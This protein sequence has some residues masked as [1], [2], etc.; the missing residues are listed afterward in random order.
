M[1]SDSALPDVIDRFLRAINDQ[2]AERAAKCFAED[3]RYYFAMPHPPARGRDAIRSTLTRVLAEVDHVQWDV[4]TSTTDGN[5]VF[6]ERLDRFW[7][8][9]AEAAIECVGVVEIEHEL[10]E[11]FRDY[12]ELGAWKQRKAAAQ[13]RD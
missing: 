11:E 10:I 2:D 3:A 4:V 9:E 12:A 7:F 8:G 13:N 5:R 1:S 6:L